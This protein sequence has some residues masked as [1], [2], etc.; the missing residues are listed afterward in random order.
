M[1][2]GKTLSLA[3]YEPVL[4]PLPR[5]VLWVVVVCVSL[6][7]PAPAGSARNTTFPSGATMVAKIPVPHASG[8]L[9]V[10]LGGVWAMKD[11]GSTLYRIDPRRNVVVAR[12]ALRTP[13]TCPTFPQSCGEVAVGDGAVWVAEPA[14]NAVERVDP[15]TNAIAASIPVG[16]QPAGVAVSP[17]AVWVASLRGPSVSRIDPKTNQVVASIA[18]GPAKP[19]CGDHIT[20]AWGDGGVWVTLEKAGA[21]ARLDPTSKRVSTIPVGWFRFGQPCGG[22]L[23]TPAAVWAGGAHCPTSSGYAVVIRIDPHAEKVVGAVKGVRSP[24]GLVLASGSLWIADLDAKSVERVDPASGRIVGKLVVGG[25][26]IGLVAGY[27]ALW[28]GDGSGHVLRLAPAH[29]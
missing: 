13:K 2:L 16:K 26:P 6:A 17:D 10:G 29:N 9:A 19:C 12:I 4:A 18:V 25:V 23:V 7:A 20:V 24:I 22:L 27:R 8:A 21:V 15:R 1:R 11:D 5:S 28:V 14:A 3:E